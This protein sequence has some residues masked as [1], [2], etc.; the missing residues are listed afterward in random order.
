MGLSLGFQK[1]CLFVMFLLVSITEAQNQNQ[2]K[3]FDVR[4]YGAVSDG[5]TDNSKVRNSVQM[6]LLYIYII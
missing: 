2:Y 5:K 3:A 1:V 4:K 6:M